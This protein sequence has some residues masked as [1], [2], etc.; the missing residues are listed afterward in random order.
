M[1]I[2]DLEDAVSPEA[3]VDARDAA[4]AAAAE[5]GFGNRELAIRI[6]ALDTPGQG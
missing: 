6:N 2:L 5:G 4:I 3:K 1:I